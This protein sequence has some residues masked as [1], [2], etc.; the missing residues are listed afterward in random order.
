[1]QRLVYGANANVM[2][3]LMLIALYSSGGKRVMHARGK[4]GKCNAMVTGLYFGKV[5]QPDALSGIQP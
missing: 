3:T 2:L 4:G 1:M 5:G